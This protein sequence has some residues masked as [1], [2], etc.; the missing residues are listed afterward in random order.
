MTEAIRSLSDKEL[1]E[2]QDK[3][4]ITVCGH[5]LEEGDLR[6]MYKFDSKHGSM[7]DAHADQQVR[8]KLFH[9]FTLSEFFFTSFQVNLWKVGA[10]TQV[11]KSLIGAPLVFL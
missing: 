1:M 3:G 5:V 2:F 11:T 7:Y 10:S 9:S 4:K 8:F 6:L